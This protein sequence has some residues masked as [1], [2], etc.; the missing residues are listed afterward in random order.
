LV[1]TA[2]VLGL[3]PVGVS[4]APATDAPVI[5]EVEPGLRQQLQADEGTGYLIYFHERPDLSKAYAMDWITRGRFVTAALQATAER[6]QARVRAYLDAQGADYQAFWIDNVIAVEKSNLKTFNTLTTAFPE[7]EALRAHRQLQLYE[8]TETA[9]P[10]MTSSAIEPNISHVLADQVWAEGYTGQGIVVASVDTGVRYTHNALVNHYR[11]NLGGGTFD[12]NYNWWDPYG[13]HPTAPGDDNGHGTHTMGTMVGDDGGANQIGMA[14]GAKWMACRGCNTSSCTDTAL[15]ECAEFFAAPW[16][17]TGAN[18][19]PDKRPNAVNNSWGDCSRSYDPWYQDVVNAWHAAG[20]YPVFSNGNASNCGYPAPPGLNTVGNPARYGNVTGVGSS[21]R[22]NGQYATHSNWGPTDNPDTVNPKPGWADLKPQVLAPGVNIRSSVNSGDSAYQ[23]GWSG[24]SMSAPHVTGLVALMWSAAPCLIGDYAT[25][26]TI[27]EDTATPIPYDDG[28]GG[29]AHVPNYAT[30]WGEINALAAVEAAAASCGDS[31]IVGRVTDATT[32]APIAGATVVATSE[33]AQRQAT[34][35]AEGLYV[36]TVFSGTYTLAAS[37]YGYRTTVIPDVLATTGTT[38]T[39]NI[40]L[41]PAAMYE[42]S[43]KV[44]DATTGWPLYAHISI[45]GDPVGPLPPDNSAWTNPATGAYSLMLAEGVT[46]TLEVEAWVDGYGVSTGKVGPLTAD[47]PN[48]DFAV[49]PDM[50]ACTAPGYHFVGGLMANFE[51]K[52]FPPAGWTVV[53]NGGTCDWVGN[54]PGGRGNLTGGTGKFAI[55]DS[56]AC[57]SGT[58]MNTD[59]VSPPFDVSG[60]SQ[61]NLSFAYDYN[62]YTAG[63]VAAV[64]VSANNGATW[65]NVVTWTTDQRGPAT[66]SQNVTG[67]LAGSTQARVRFHYYAPSWDWWWQVDNVVLGNPVCQ[68]PTDG[69]LVVGNVYDA[70]FPTLALNGA[71]VVNATGGETTAVATPA[72]PA[73]DDAF[74]TLFAP[75]GA[76]AFTAMMKGGYAP[77]TAT[78]TVVDGDVVKH[79]FFLPAGLLSAT[80]TG[81]DV[82]VELGYTAARTLTLANTGGAS[83]AFELKEKA[84]RFAPI[85]I[86]AYTGT[87][88]P[89]DVP[90]S[91][92]KAP[93]GK[94]PTEAPE[95]PAAAPLADAAPAFAIDLFTGNLVAFMSDTPGTWTDIGNTGIDGPFAGDFLNGDFGQMYVLD[96]YTNGF[97][98]VDTATAA[99]TLVGTS[100]P[101]SGQVWTGMTGSVDGVLYAASTNGSQSY[102]YTIDPAT[103]VATVVGEITNAPVIIDI[104]INA[105]GEMYGVEIMNDVL[106]S[107]DPATGAG[108]VIGSLGFNASY[109]QG[110]DFEEESGVLYLAAFN[111]GTSQ[112]EFRIADTATGNTVL[113]GGFPGGAEVDCLSFA[114]G[115]S[116]DVPWLTEAPTAGSVAAS[117]ST[118]IAVDFDAAYVGQPG[119]Y[120]AD[121]IV[122]NDTPYGK[123]SVPVTMTVTAPTSWGKLTGTVTGLGVCD[124]DPAPLEEAEVRV[125]SATTGQV[126]TLATDEN[127]RYTLWFDQAHSPVTITVTAPDYFGETGGVVVKQGKTTVVDFNLRLLKP[128]LSYNPADFDVTLPMGNNT[129]EPLT[130]SNTGA[131]TA[132]FELVEKPGGFVPL[133]RARVSR[134][135]IGDVIGNNAFTVNPRPASAPSASYPAPETTEGMLILTHSVSQEIIAGNSVACNNGVAHTDNSYLRTFYLPDF[136][137]T[138]D[139]SVVEV[140]MGIEMAAGGSGVQPVEVR[141]YTLDG[142]LQWENMTLIGQAAV[143]IS[144]Q[145][146]THFTIPVTGVAPAGSTL[147]VEFFT[148]DGSADSNL[149]FVGSN[150]FGQTAPSYLAAADCGVTE[151]TDVAD[152]GFP[153]MH[154]VMNVTGMTGG[155][156]GIPWLTETPISG[157]LAA[158]T[159]VVVDLGFDAGVPETMQPGTYYGALKVASDAANDVPNI[160]IT[161]TVTP[162]ESWGKIAGVVT[163][164]GYCDVATP[165]L[166]AGAVV[167]LTSGT[168]LIEWTLATDENGA[169]QFWLDEAHSPVT[170]T[171]AYPDH[172]TQVLTKVEVTAGATTVADAALRWAKPC[173]TVDPDMFNVSVTLGTSATVPFSLKNLGASGTTFALK[174]TNGGVIPMRSQPVILKAAA[175]APVDV[176]TAPASA[177][178]SAPNYTPLTPDILIEEGFEG[179][180]VPPVGWTEVTNSTVNWE[181]DDYSPHS[182][183]YDAHVLYDYNQNEWL[184]SPEM[185]LSR[186]TLSFWSYGSVYWCRDTY[187]NCDLNVWIVVGPNVGDGDDI[188]VGTADGDWPDNWTWAQSVFDLTPL[189]PGGPVRIGFQYLGDDGAEAALDD[190]VLDGVEGGSGAGIPWLFEDPE[191]GAVAADDT[192]VVDLTFDATSAVTQVTQIGEYFGTLFVNS[193]D[194]VHNKIAVPVTMTVTPP[195]TWGKLLGTVT[196]LGYCDADPAPLAGANVLVEG[197]SGMTWTVT[198]DVSGTYQLWLDESESPVAVTVEAPEH[199]KGEATGV[200]ITGGATTTQDFDLR[201]L[202]PCVQADPLALHTTLELGTT[203]SEVLTLTNA[204]AVDT[205]WSLTEENLGALTGTPPQV[206][207]NTLLEES[208]ENATFPPTGWVAYNIDGGGSQWVRS[209]AR[210]YAGS[211]SA[212]HTYSSVG[213]QDGW[214]VTPAVAV[215][216]V[217]T[218]ALSFWEYT[219]Y[220]TWYVKHSLWVCT[221]GCATPPTNW[222]Q[223]TEFGAP[224]SAWR[225]QTVNLGAYAGQT[226]YLAFRYEGYDADAWNIDAVRIYQDLTD[227]V[228]WLAETPT[229]GALVADTG[230]QV[231]AVDF[232]ASVTGI[233]QPGDYLANLWVHSDD[234]FAPTIV[235]V[236]MTVTPP[237]TWGELRGTVTSL[238]RCDA[239]PAPLEGATVV[240]VNGTSVMLTTDVN[241][242]YSYWLPAGT[243]TVTVAAAD[244]VGAKAGVTV[245]AAG[246]VT[247]DFSLTWL[248]PCV[249]SI[250]PSSMEVTVA[251]GMSETLLLTMTNAGAGPL[252]FAFLE[253]NGGFVP[254]LRMPLQQ[255]VQA[256][257][258][259]WNA[260]KLAGECAA[261]A[262]SPL[263]EPAEALACYDH[264]PEPA[265][266]NMPFAPG[267]TGYAQDIGYVSDN[268]VTFT[269][270]NFAGQTVVGTSSNA[271]YGM[272]FDPS[273]TTLYAL[274]D[275]TDQLGTINLTTGAFTGLVP[276]PPGGGAA[277]WT[278]LTIDPINGTFYASTATDL[279][280]INPTTGASTLVGP[281]GTS[282]MIDIAM[283][284]AG[285][286]YGHDIGTDSIYQIDPATGAATLVGP[287]GYNANYAQGMDFDNDDGTLYIFLYQGSGANVFGTVNLTTGAVTPLSVSAP[288][289]E[290]EGAIQI[291]GAKPIPWLFEDPESGAVP[292]AT[293]G[294]A[295]ITFDA[296]VPEVTQ[297]GTYAGLLT[298]NNN[299]PVWDGFSIPVTMHVT[300]PP[301]YGQITGAVTGLGPCDDPATAGPLEGA[302]VTIASATQTWTLTTDAA[303]GYLLWLDE[304]HSPVTLTVEA[305][306]YVTGVVTGVQVISGTTTVQDFVLRSEVPCMSIEPAEAHVTVTLGMTAT[307]PITV[308]NTGAAALS[309]K[310][311]EADGGFQI[312]SGEDVLVVAYDTTAATSMETALTHLG[313]T[314]LRVTRDAFQAMAVAD[315]LKYRAVLYAGGYSSDSWAKAMAY[316]D[317][318]GSFLIADNDLGYGNKATTFYQTYLQS[319]Y[320]SD[321]GSDGQLTGLDIMTGIN[322][323]ISADPYPDDFTVGA[324]GTCIFDAPSPNCAGVKV[325]RLGYKAIYL[326]WDFQ[327]SGGLQDAILGVAVPWLAGGGGVPWLD[328]DPTSGT[329]APDAKGPVTLTFDASVP[330]VAQPGDYYATLTFEGADAEVEVP[331]TMTVEP[332]ATYG[333]ITGAVTGLGPCDDPATAGPLEGVTVTI[334]SATQ[335]WIL[336]TDAAGGY[337]LWLDE[338]HSPVT[339]TVE[340]AGYVT[341]VVTGVPIISGTT[342]VQDVALRPK[343]PCFAGVTPAEAHVTVALGVTATLPITVVNTGGGALSWSVKEA[344]GGFQILAL[345]PAADVLVVAYDTTAATS[346]ETALTNLGYTYL[347][348]TRDAFQAMAVADL[349]EYQAVLYAGGYSSDSWAKARAYLDAGGSFLIADNDLGW[350]Q[351]GT[352]FYQTY[353][354]STYV[355]DAGSDGQLTGLDIMTGINPNIS[356]DPYPDDFTVGAEGTCIF[357]APSPNCAGVKVERLDYKAI[358]LAWD[359]QYSG[360][361]QDAI[362]GV[363]V[364]WL[365]G[366]GGVPWLDEDPT[367]GTVAPDAKAPVTLT[368]DA[369]VPEVTQPGDYYATLTFK[370]AGAE[371]E[372]PVTM[373]VE[374]PATWGKLAG[375]VQGLGHCNVMTAPLESAVVF[376]ESAATPIT[377]TLETDADGMYGVWMDEAYSPFTVT[378]SYEAGYEAQV[379]TGVEVHAGEVTTLNAD[380]IWLQPCLTV[381]PDALALSVTMGSTATL[382]LNLANLGAITGTFVIT[383]QSLGFEILGPLAAGGPDAFGYEFADSNSAGIHPVYG[384]VDISGIGTPI[385]LGDNDYAEVPIGFDFKFYGKSATEPNVYSSVFVGSNGFLSF[386]AGSTDLSPD[387]ALPDPTLPNNLIAAAWDNLVPGTV[388][389]QSFAQ[390]PY[391]PSPTTL[392]GCFIVQYDD[393]SHA[394]G[395]PAGT[396]EV[397]L[398][399]SGNILLQYENVSAPHATTGIEDRLGLIGLNYGPTLANKLAICFAYPGEKTNC[400]SDQVPWLATEVTKGKIAA[401]DDATIAVTFDASVP[402]VSM[403]GDYL[404]ELWI[405][406]N[407]PVNSPQVI[408]VT[409][410][411][412]QPTTMGRLAG[413]VSGWSHCDTVSE[414][415]AGAQVVIATSDGK[416]VVLT[417]DADGA[418]AAWLPVGPYTLTVSAEGYVPV[419]LTGAVQPTMQSRSVDLRLDAPCVSVTY[420]QPF[421]VV[422]VQ[423]QRLTR[424]LT[425]NNRGAGR[426]TYNNVLA[427]GLWLTVDPKAG[428]VAPDS[429]QP[430]NVIF[431]ATGLDVGVYNSSMEIVHNDTKSGR[432]FIRPIRMT[433][434]AQGTVLTPVTDAKTGNPGETV[435]YVMTVTN[436]I[437]TAVTFD[438]AATG[439]VWTT[440][441][442]AT[443]TVAANGTVT[444]TVD[445]DIPADAHT[446]DS[447]TVIVKVTSQGADGQVGEAVLQTTVAEQPVVLAL[448]KAANPADY[449]LPGDTI[450]Y[451]LTLANNG[452]DP[453]TIALTD[454]IPAGVTYVAGSV[455]GGASLQD[456]P[457]AIV[458][459]GVLAKGAQH[460]ITFKVTIN[461]DVARGSLITNTVTATVGGVPYTAQATVVVG[462]AIL[463]PATD[464]KTGNPGETVTYVM[465][466][467]NFIARAVTFDIAA[468][469][470]V[471]TTTAPATVTVAANGTVTFTVDVD[472]PVDAHAGDSDTVIVKVTS[473]GAD[474]QVGEAVLQTT[475]AEQPVVLALT[476]AAN[477]ADYVLPGDVVT[478]TLTLANKGNDPLTIA[479]TDTIPAGVTYVAGSATGGASLQDPPGAIV[480]K[481]VLANGAQ[482]TFTFKVTINANV[483]RGSLITNTVTA[484]V[485]G[486][487][488]TAQA[489]VHVRPLYSIYLPLVFRNAP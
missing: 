435:T 206:V 317:A 153:D 61:V 84:G 273:A 120:H 488:Y 445:V 363:A 199:E 252:N 121:L 46:Y 324:E 59:L 406:S 44:T 91:T 102:L 197:S 460:I 181:L 77:D 391:N 205:A 434:V 346:M 416:N 111:V 356:A 149:L 114:T 122:K 106:M 299:D 13:D 287:T 18:A 343:A 485:G 484:T 30:G 198:T 470:N 298:V 127:G 378:V 29:G 440:T 210:A 83:A 227:Q 309:W 142:D 368:F 280:I 37:R 297:P 47:A 383:E 442:P 275:S 200:T 449:V 385:A 408:P 194:P 169:Y 204:G 444:F 409:M 90:V 103:G 328:E 487:P 453:L 399:H 432:L 477:P 226:I 52:T 54:D 217:G 372:V 219:A 179:G 175:A 382:N 1:L 221:S 66:F 17:L 447:D 387:P 307:T 173:L 70:N 457:G 56:D 93:Q 166:L 62:N 232:D 87:L 244:H 359:F 140:D 303:G 39:Q 150:N 418:Y 352:V 119:E 225:Q 15:L 337:L 459:K 255:A 294:V 99:A 379:F 386:G 80:P 381:A 478:Y 104:A 360:G 318:G 224:T 483:A 421:D 28:T 240:I 5:V 397:I 137:I 471:W 183:L 413:V 215:P 439:N 464:A 292:P 195:A 334:A 209:T 158:D 322:P 295:D 31:A 71:T 118:A 321:A 458:W 396:W 222:T 4:A 238:G 446:G 139:F 407:D 143:E 265:V 284:P 424:T 146:L 133:N 489:T 308:V 172:V 96:Y 333:K 109:A 353:L 405:A 218:S 97:Y 229:S 203:A 263:A 180:A 124:G 38:T 402:E 81:L 27:I 68:P 236:T 279:Y 112:G 312:M 422:V 190:I 331:V 11:G 159:H 466:V 400:Q 26:E 389:V 285:E 330:E 437:A 7:V 257:S 430:V 108:A 239:N 174:E 131:G 452:N 456:P 429:A 350:S 427:T 211:A 145:E 187:D 291:P 390:C 85:H 45:S 367:S 138:T 441:A 266:F 246:E 468:T 130:L 126:W 12:H 461:A 76:Q 472:I 148:P 19:N 341:G 135:T 235:P 241:G 288:L 92:G 230:E 116:V 419:T 420:D 160:P 182:G 269:L 256:S 438:I 154:I 301:T 316:L 170:I 152:L 448:T 293:D 304:A 86:A 41:T 233:E 467:T 272:D 388:Y 65:V 73:V 289:G 302:E 327:Y 189:L 3:F 373:T 281:F 34:S 132:E 60:L 320:V 323:N 277:N 123:F 392:E 88:P 48:T 207:Q 6:S 426:L 365:A 476:K 403:P 14:P 167:T 8:A 110:M 443:V 349:L 249:T 228:T 21:G 311:K 355:S 454:T 213:T 375:L 212:F 129:V 185:A 100:A 55:A 276:C 479:L 156:G 254:T 234:P 237:A 74:Y 462:G 10:A 475:V 2:M 376:V 184:L 404:A 101:L 191:S 261:Y 315:L 144:D 371:V 89:S 168:G 82:T 151:P 247:Q 364:P 98:I 450:T 344:D 366:G 79:D 161:L 35:N 455:T 271:Y 147:V 64:D 53:N 336:T 369:S 313:Y 196:G 290:F 395:A 451:T 136:D 262:D 305:D 193:N 394:G 296:G 164:L 117:G 165:T 306:G 186:G 171:V 425:L 157:T 253:A 326:A 75:S 9:S 105:D 380:L 335:M 384:F 348:V 223:V 486:V 202:V 113:V 78:V 134:V 24:T 220:A 362:L 259:T 115:G 270:D 283:N 163:G 319:T 22:D 481:G 310:V 141:L 260:E 162:P 370:G 251:M 248:G 155:A 258:V 43:G 176:R 177:G 314:Y 268:F 361:L 95:A 329:V 414:T 214:L 412:T 465:T 25:T 340:A 473:Q 469:G 57:G 63:E 243:Y 374:R 201:W 36:L 192:F 286:M 69:G 250:T 274:N 354:Q 415:L 417:T 345:S 16:D 410:T 178:M 393:F 463:T 433:V 94:T 325:E 231:V 33:M 20:I 411:V 49:Q 278:G 282:L 342:T 401:Y 332:P 107:I 242:A 474:G 188:Y 245:P 436:S 128:C 358:Y 23:G 428:S 51:D 347:Q 216:A 264:V 338:A 72:D 423:G 377:W 67:I 32:S 125:E 40:A 50:V 267:D 482:Q 357:D 431:D 398:F 58:T 480:W 300:L 208:F 351:G 42:V 339:L